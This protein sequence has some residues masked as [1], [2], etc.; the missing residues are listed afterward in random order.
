MAEA[1][2]MLEGRPVHKGDLLHVHPSFH[3]RAG[4][5]VTAE[6]A[7]AG[8]EAV[9]RS[10]NGAVPCVPIDALSWMAFPDEADREIIAKAAGLT[11]PFVTTRD[12]RMFRLGRATT[13]PAPGA[14][15]LAQ[16][17][18]CTKE[19]EAPP[20]G[21]PCTECGSRRCDGECT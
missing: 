4:V 20:P 15:D 3:A 18:Q 7:A 11:G 12:L 1:L 9:C 16:P 2:F 14:P 13:Q 17:Q 8:G 19:G 5:R 21:A 10:D 6:F